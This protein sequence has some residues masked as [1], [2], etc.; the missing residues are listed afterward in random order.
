MNAERRKALNALIGRIEELVSLR[1]GIVS[2]LESI[3][4]EEQEGYDNMP[5]AFQ[6]GEKGEKAQ[7]AVSAMEDALSAMEGFDDVTGYLESAAE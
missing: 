1:D 5:E 3:R 2:D 4:D 7:A 6:N